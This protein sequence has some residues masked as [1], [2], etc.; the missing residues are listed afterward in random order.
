MYNI[1]ACYERF[2]KFS[3]AYKWF[4]RAVQT[5]PKMDIAHMGAALNL[6]K[7]GKFKKAVIFIEEAILA[8][9]GRKLETGCSDVNAVE[10][11]DVEPWDRGKS[12]TCT[13]IVNDCKHMLA[14][15]LRKLQNFEE[16]QTLYVK[17]IRWY[18]YAERRALVDSIFGLLLLPLETD[19]RTIADKLEIMRNSML[20]YG[21]ANEPIRRPLSGTFWKS[22]RDCWEPFPAAIAKELKTRRFFS[23]F[24][25]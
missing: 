25:V 22:E 9:Q 23:R 5:Q 21:K 12:T 15:C 11:E 6:F 17:N 4:R 3:C 8:L 14:M 1:A 20:D 2:N 13:A 10:Q 24:E 19:R 18:R 16:A 7:L